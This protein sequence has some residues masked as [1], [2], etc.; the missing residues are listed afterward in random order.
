M[1]CTERPDD[2]EQRREK[3]KG[4]SDE[5]LHRYFWQLVEQ[6]VEPLIDEARTH[7]TPSIERSVL[8]RM[9]FSSIEAKQLVE[10]MLQRNVLGHGAGRLILELAKAKRL[11]IR[12]TGVALLSGQYWEELPV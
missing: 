12:E 3:L 10:K 11:S 7:T 6:I 2:F 5:E 8:L 4:M 9:G 1:H